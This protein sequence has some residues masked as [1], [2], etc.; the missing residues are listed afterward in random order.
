[1]INLYVSVVTTQVGILV[2][3]IHSSHYAGTSLVFIRLV[4]LDILISSKSHLSQMFE[5]FPERKPGKANHK[6]YND[7]AKKA[8]YHY[9]LPS[10]PVIYNPRRQ[11]LAPQSAQSSSGDH[12]SLRN[13]GALWCFIDSKRSPRILWHV[14]T[15]LTCWCLQTSSTV[16]LNCLAGLLVLLLPSSVS[17][18]V[19][20]RAA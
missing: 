12:N 3:R 8:K 5:P 16:Q 1:M 14:A 7:T 19:V 20:V 17:R 13:G 15:I 11:H 6:V 9:F 18:G 2:I 4:V 10:K